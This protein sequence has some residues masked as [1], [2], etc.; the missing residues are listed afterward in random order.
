MDKKSSRGRIGGVG[1]ER[2]TAPQGLRPGDPHDGV[3]TKLGYS[4]HLLDP[5]AMLA[6]AAVMREGEEKGYEEDGWRQL[7]SRIHINHAIGHLFAHLGGDRAE[8]HLSHAACRI[9]MAWAVHEHEWD[10]GHKSKTVYIC[11]P[12]KDDPIVNTS[13]AVAYGRYIYNQY[14]DG[15]T[16]IIPHLTMQWWG[17]ETEDNREQIL[18]HCMRLVALCDELVV[19]GDTITSGMQAEIDF[20]RHIGTQISKAVLNKET[21]AEYE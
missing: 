15:T 19:C 1:R 14:G 9:L 20:A 3:H 8:D 5:W 11:H 2:G 13:M 18:S 17:E 4:F 7:P 10:R 16:I 12:Y 6:L 21:E